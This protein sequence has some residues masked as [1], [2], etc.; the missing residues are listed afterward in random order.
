MMGL[1]V[2]LTNSCKKDDNNTNNENTIKDFDGNIYHSV[3]IGTQIWMVEN[4]KVTHYRNSDPITNVTSDDAWGK[5]TTEAFCYYMNN[6]YNAN[7]YGCLY[8]F[9]AAT[10]PRSITP[11]GWHVP[12]KDEW[13]ILINYLNGE[14]IAGGKLKETGT[15]HWQ[16]PNTGATNEFGFT[17]L[18]GGFRFG[19]YYEGDCAS[20]GTAAILWTK[21]EVINA[22]GG[23]S[24]YYC[25]ISNDNSE[26]RIVYSSRSGGR[27]IRCIKD[28][29]N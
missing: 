12:S 19:D 16:S 9:Y 11:S 27:S 3:T 13:T 23:T 28:K 29:A 20:L 24:A 10:D 2:M 8:N 7:T 22:S 25:M 5:R 6:S 18:P 1:L 15:T 4:L 21:D 26:A 14:Q 17:A